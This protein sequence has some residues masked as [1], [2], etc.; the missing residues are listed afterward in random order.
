MTHPE[1]DAGIPGVWFFVSNDRPFEIHSMFLCE[2]SFPRDPTIL[3]PSIFGTR[4][5]AKN[6]ILSTLLI[7][8]SIPWRVVAVNFWLCV[9]DPHNP[10]GPWRKEMNTCM[11]IK[12]VALAAVL[13]LGLSTT[14]ASAHN[15]WHGGGHHGHSGIGHVHVPRYTPVYPR[16]NVYRAPVWHDNTHLDWHGPTIRRH[17]NHLHIQRGHYDVHRSGHWH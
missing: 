13:A 10:A 9:S 1:P 15:H 16:Y 17:G 8:A 11:A 2:A 7:I 4:L 5:H 12:S 14:S 3:L 6:A